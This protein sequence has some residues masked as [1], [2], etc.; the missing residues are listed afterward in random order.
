[1][2]LNDLEAL[3]CVLPCALVN[4]LAERD[5]G[6]RASWEQAGSTSEIHIC[7]LNSGQIS[8]NSVTFFFF[9]TDRG[10]NLLTR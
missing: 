5:R 4:S 3:P 10:T 8:F 6:G 9:L 2:S 7:R 1:M